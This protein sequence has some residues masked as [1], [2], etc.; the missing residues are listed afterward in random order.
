MAQQNQDSPVQPDQDD[1]IGGT[2]GVAVVL[3]G[4]VLILASLPL[5]IMPPFGFLLLAAGLLLLFFGSRNHLAARKIRR[6]PHR[7]QEEKMR[8]M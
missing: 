5:M 3:L 6:N 1:V 2:W 8:H 4:V 7:P